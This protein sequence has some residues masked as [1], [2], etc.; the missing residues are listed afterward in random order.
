MLNPGDYPSKYERIEGLLCG[1][2][3]ALKFRWTHAPIGWSMPFQYPTTSA[4]KQSMKTNTRLARIKTKIKATPLASVPK[5]DAKSAAPSG[6]T[7]SSQESSTARPLLPIAIALAVVVLS[8]CVLYGKTFLEL[9]YQWRTQ[10]DYSHG[11]LVPLL[12]IALLYSRRENFTGWQRQLCWS[13]AALLILAMVL[14]TLGQLFF[15]EFL[16][17]WSIIPWLAGCITLLAGPRMLWWALP[18]LLFLLFMVPLPYQIESTLSWKLQSLVTTLSSIVLRI[19]GFPAVAEGHTI[20][21]GQSQMLVEEAC[22]GLRIFVGMAAFAY[23]WA[24]LIRRAWVD[25]LVVIASFIPLAI[26]A[27]TIRSVTICISYYWF[28]GRFARF[29][30]DFAGILMIVLAAGMV[31][32]V[33]QH[34]ERLYRPVWISIPANRLRN[35]KEP[36]TPFNR[37]S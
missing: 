19:F 28:D 23:F 3:E 14:R 2:L 16:E 29:V 35:K 34:W 26:A 6:L 15:M 9:E 30:H 13:G 18:S 8:T 24:C 20:W 21:I 27:N 11:Y 10:A 4:T 33:K 32:L 5:E 22:S 36:V 37:Q 7:H 12:S 1:L 31:W 17:A 25:K